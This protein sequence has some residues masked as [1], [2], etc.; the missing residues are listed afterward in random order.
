M[1]GN[2]PMTA[3]WLGTSSLPILLVTKMWPTWNFITLSLWWA[4][5]LSHL[6]VVLLTDIYSSFNHPYQNG[7]KIISN[8][9]SNQK[10]TIHTWHNPR[11]ALVAYTIWQSWLSSN[12]L[13]NTLS[14]NRCIHKIINLANEFHFFISK[15]RMGTSVRKLL[16]ILDSSLIPMH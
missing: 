1:Y 3:S 4:K 10:N 11:G 2:A 6:N 13:I 8:P 9:E 5:H 12:A 15:N 14:K 7:F 16:Y